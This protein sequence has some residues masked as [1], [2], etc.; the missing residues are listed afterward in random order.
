MPTLGPFVSTVKARFAGVGSTLPGLSMVRAVNVCGPSSSVGAVVQAPK[1]P[2]S[3]LHWNVT[4]AS[5][6]AILK[7]GV[8]SVV[9]PLGP[10]VIVV[11]GGTSS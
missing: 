6:A 8:L 10:P 11:S 7:F 9:R 1:L 2:P 4:F 3:K 5:F